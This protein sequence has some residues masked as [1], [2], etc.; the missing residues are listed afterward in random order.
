[1]R[2]KIFG[3]I[4]MENKLNKIKNY[5]KENSDYI[6][7]A[8]GMIMTYLMGCYVGYKCCGET[9]AIGIEEITNGDVICKNVQIINKK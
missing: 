9:V 6:M 5:V 7:V 3:G 1:M 8:S 2:N 4:F